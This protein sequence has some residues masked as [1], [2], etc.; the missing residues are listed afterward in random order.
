ML[1]LLIHFTAK[2]TKVSELLPGRT[3]TPRLSAQRSCPVAG[4]HQAVHEASAFH[5]V[6]WGELWSPPS[7]AGQGS[8]F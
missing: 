4:A 1:E 3:A 5:S 8:L 2:K 7:Q 6:K